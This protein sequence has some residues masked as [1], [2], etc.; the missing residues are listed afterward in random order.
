MK[1]SS[2][3]DR[4]RQFDKTLWTKLECIWRISL[5]ALITIVYLIIVYV[6]SQSHYDFLF[7]IINICTNIVRLNSIGTANELFHRYFLLSLIIF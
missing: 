6:T 7:G 3:D 1:I 4:E 2:D 5:S